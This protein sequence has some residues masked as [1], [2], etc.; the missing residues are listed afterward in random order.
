[1]SEHTG[2]SLGAQMREAVNINLGLLALKKCI[3]ALNRGQSHVPYQDS[4]LTMLLSPALGGN[5]K[6]SV[7]VCG[8]MEA[9][10]AKETV[11]VEA[12]PPRAPKFYAAGPVA[13]V[14]E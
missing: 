12:T 7:V 13:H 9:S 6:C 2:F 10:D 1:M 14:S 5:S 11:Q 4:K 3:D 8:S